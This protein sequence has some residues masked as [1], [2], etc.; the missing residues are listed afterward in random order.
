MAQLC[1]EVW[2][3]LSGNN[4]NSGAMGSHTL[5]C[6]GEERKWSYNPLVILAVDPT[7]I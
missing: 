4:G 6:Y 7:T 5:V 3:V 2:A 1:L